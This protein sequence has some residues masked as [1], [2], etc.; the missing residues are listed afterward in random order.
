MVLGLQT[1]RWPGRC[2]HEGWHTSKPGWRKASGLGAGLVDVRRACSAC[3]VL[4]LGMVQEEGH[5][6][7][8]KASGLVISLGNSQMRSG[9]KR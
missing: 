6:G 8:Q 2:S 3:A 7:L 9:A 1:R 4:L 5:T